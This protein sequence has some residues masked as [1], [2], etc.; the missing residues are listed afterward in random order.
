MIRRDTYLGVVCFAALKSQFVA[1]VRA[2]LMQVWSDIFC[3]RRLQMSLPDVNWLPT[4]IVVYNIGR[5][6]LSSPGA[7]LT[8]RYFNMKCLH[9]YQFI[10]NCSILFQMTL[11]ELITITSYSTV[12]Q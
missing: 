3:A 11:G 7:R 8:P 9:H 1:S 6:S 4:L 10:C 2:L 12:R 5:A